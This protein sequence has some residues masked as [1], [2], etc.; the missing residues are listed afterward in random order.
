M[1]FFESLGKMIVYEVQIASLECDFQ[2]EL[3]DELD[4]EEKEVW[5]L[6]LIRL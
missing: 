5:Q 1:K 4:L 6:L 2:S 3:L